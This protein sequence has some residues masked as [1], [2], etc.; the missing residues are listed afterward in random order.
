MIRYQFNTVLES[1]RSWARS[2]WPWRG[3]QLVIVKLQIFAD[4]ITCRWRSWAMQ[5]FISTLNFLIVSYKNESLKYSFK[6]WSIFHFL[7]LYFFR[8][9]DITVRQCRNLQISYK[10]PVFIK[11]NLENCTL[12][13]LKSLFRPFMIAFLFSKQIATNITEIATNITW[14]FL[15]ISLEDRLVIFH[16]RPYTFSFRT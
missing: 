16:K 4:I 9:R 10:N 3:R 6:N 11:M 2:T 12:K 13:N 7:H 14:N 1:K 8:M 5:I 15:F